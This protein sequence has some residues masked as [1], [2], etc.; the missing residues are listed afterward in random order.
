MMD[1]A[2]AFGVRVHPLWAG[3]EPSKDER[4]RLAPPDA[5]CLQIVFTAAGSYECAQI[6]NCSCGSLL[7]SVEKRCL[8][9]EM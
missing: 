2:V 1:K 9:S 3:E 6:P 8:R 5:I 7:F 4:H